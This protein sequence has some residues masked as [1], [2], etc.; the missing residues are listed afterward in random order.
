MTRHGGE[1]RKKNVRKDRMM[2]KSCRLNKMKE[3]LT[4]E[5]QLTN[6][7]ESSSENEDLIMTSDIWL[8]RLLVTKSVLGVHFEPHFSNIA[9]CM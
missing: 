6:L 2:K 8:Q 3:S 1:R 7:S 5:K 9:S 4:D